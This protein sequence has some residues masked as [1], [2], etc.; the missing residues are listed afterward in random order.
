LC[1]YKLTTDACNV[2]AILYTGLLQDALEEALLMLCRE[3]P[4]IEVEL[5]KDS[6]QTVLKGIG[7]LHLEV[8]CDRYADNLN[9][10][11]LY[12]LMRDA[13]SAHKHAMQH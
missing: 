9:I 4:S 3:D 1:A 2:Y 6:G 7:E 11:K 13:D 5:D 12:T 8:V 10:I